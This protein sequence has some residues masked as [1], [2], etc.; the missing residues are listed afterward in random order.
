M[1]VKGR[2]V[3]PLRSKYR[4]DDIQPAQRA[5]EVRNGLP[6]QVCYV[7]HDRDAARDREVAEQLAAIRARITAADGEG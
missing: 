4:P 3:S 7:W 2:V 6:E 5:V 1:S